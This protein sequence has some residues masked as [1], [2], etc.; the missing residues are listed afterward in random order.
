M[1][2]TR[3]VRDIDAELLAAYRKLRS[4]KTEKT[5]RESLARIDALLDERNR[6]KL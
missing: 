1:T 2:T 4:T 6:I 5:K 3:T